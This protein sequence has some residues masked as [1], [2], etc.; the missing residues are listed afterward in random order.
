MPSPVVDALIGVV[1]RIAGRQMPEARGG[2]YET[3]MNAV[4]EGRR[5]ALAAQMLTE[6]DKN[7]LEMKSTDRLPLE[8]H[9]RRSRY[10][11][12]MSSGEH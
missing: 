7:D 5:T 1:A 11:V 10:V 4:S 3:A 2:H 9:Y 12:M 6:A 8:C